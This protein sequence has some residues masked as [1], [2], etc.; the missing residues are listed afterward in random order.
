MLTPALFLDRDGVINVDHAYVHKIEDFQFIDGIFELCR[1]AQGQGRRLFVVTNQ[2]GI[3]RGYYTE[4]DF[5]T[6]TRWMCA[7]FAEQGVTIDQV[8]F[9][10]SHPEHGLGPY[11]TES[12]DRKPQPGMLLQAQHAFGV[13]MARSIM[14]GDK[15][16]DMAAGLAAGVGTTLL[17]D[18]TGAAQASDCGAT[19]VITRLEEAMGFGSLQ[20]LG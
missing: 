12:F 14:I 15:P 13:D 10:P 17:F 7:R 2:A 4:E 16:S 9:C 18:P 19:A 8:Y 5:H 20:C 1:W 6:L 3:G 11:K